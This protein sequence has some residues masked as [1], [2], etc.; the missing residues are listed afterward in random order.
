MTLWAV[1]VGRR[2]RLF[3]DMHNATKVYATEVML[4][5]WISELQAPGGLWRM[6]SD[7]TGWTLVHGTVTGW[8]KP[9]PPW[10]QTE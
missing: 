3:H 7:G 8:T 10:E 2:W 6:G 5:D 9:R 1:Q 4:R